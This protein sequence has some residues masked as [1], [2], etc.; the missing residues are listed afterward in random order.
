MNELLRAGTIGN[1]LSK[2]PGVGSAVAMDDQFREHGQ[3][4]A[5]F[6]GLGSIVADL[7][8][9]CLLFSQRAIHTDGG[10][11]NRLHAV[12]SLCFK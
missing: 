1:G 2:L 12:V 8:H 9:R 3:F 11:A 4:R 10:N 5:R 7:L 6:L